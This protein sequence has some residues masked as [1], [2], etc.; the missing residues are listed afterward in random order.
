MAPFSSAVVN[1]H[2]FLH[3]LHGKLRSLLVDCSADEIFQPGA[4]LL[5]EGA[6]ADKFF[7][8]RRGLVAVEVAVPVRP[9]IV[10]E[11]VNEGEVLGWSWMIPPYRTVFSAR[12]QA[13][14]ETLTFNAQCLRAA[15]EAD[16]ELGYAISKRLLPVMAHR[17][18]AA[19]LQML[20]LYGS[21]G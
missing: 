6:V 17:L 1:E 13:E 4:Y 20:D 7:L 19:R 18:T 21:T 16:P 3:G 2:P 9:P 14:V 12:A 10:V 5:R 8:V 11:T 15:M